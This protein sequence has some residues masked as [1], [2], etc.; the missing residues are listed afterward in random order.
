MALAQISPRLYCS[1]ASLPLGFSPHTGGLERDY[2]S[3]YYLYDGL[4]YSSS[5]KQ[6]DWD[7]D[8][9]D[10]DDNDDNGST[11]GPRG[12]VVVVVYYSSCRRMEDFRVGEEVRYELQVRSISRPIPLVL[13]IE[14]GHLCYLP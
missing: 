1:V 10:D 2:Q 6:P 3:D 5:C 12:L 4:L 9:D 11:N 14:P 7:E 8:D 13:A